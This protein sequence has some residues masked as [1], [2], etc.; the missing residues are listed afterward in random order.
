MNSPFPIHLL[1]ANPANTM[2]TLSLSILLSLTAGLAPRLA[3]AG[4]IP[5]P[6][7][8]FAD[9]YTVCAARINLG[10]FVPQAW[11]DAILQAVPNQRETLTVPLGQFTQGAQ[12]WL[13][14]FRA[15]G[16]RE[17]YVLLSLSYLGMEPPILVIAPVAAGG[18]A[19]QL[20]SLLTPITGGFKGEC[21][22]L[23]NCVVAA[24]AGVWNI[25]ETASLRPASPNLE[26]ALE[27][28][29]AGLVQVAFAPYP[30]AA[31]VLEEMMPRLPAVV[32][33][34]S[35]TALSQGLRWA[36]VSLQAPPAI[37]LDLVVQSK[38]AESASA[39][40]DV[41]T[42]GLNALGAI[43]DVRKNLPGW[44]VI[45]AALTPTA[46]GNRL[47]LQINQQQLTTIAN[48]LLVPA[49]AEAR[50]K[51]TRIMVLNQLKQIALGLIMYANDHK[52][53]LPERLGEILPYV[54]TPAVLLL[55]ESP[56][57]PP[58]DLMQQDETARET[59]INNH[60]PFVLRF[61]GTSLKSI[62]DPASTILVHQ[63][64]ETAIDGRVGAAF[65]DGHAELLSTE[66][67]A[68]RLKS[69]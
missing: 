7:A 57:Q 51:A 34:G 19:A 28:T 14:G 20:Q 13:D 66:A 11:S 38:D 1:P 15:A 5:A 44:P 33:G 67:L 26:A 36:G 39:L 68:A 10:A 25:R 49:L 50:Q 53:Q 59:W 23:D 37:G 18:N 60:T 4:E 22:I 65:A 45:Q 69:Q 31:R 58:A 47:H 48:Q 21:R 29:S 24:P 17:V 2:K 43:P 41:C 40:R 55:P 52:E 62:K 16:G 12:G 42:R 64:P 46:D 6:V 8:R 30:E 61:G 63:K 9:E 32:G 54:G 56:E 3:S 35:V 27:N